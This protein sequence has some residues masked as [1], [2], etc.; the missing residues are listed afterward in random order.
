MAVTTTLNLSESHRGL[1][2]GP[3]ALAPT[4]SRLHPGP[5]GP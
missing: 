2:Q 5:G 1:Q 4:H 3:S